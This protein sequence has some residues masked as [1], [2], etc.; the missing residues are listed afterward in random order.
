MRVLAFDQSYAR[1]GVGIAEDNKLLFCI[2]Y[3]LKYFKDKTQKRLFV[4]ALVKACIHR[5]RPDT[6]IVE[7]VRVFSQKFISKNTIGALATLIAAIID[8]SRMQV[9]SVETRAWKARVLGSAKATKDDAVKFVKRFGFEVDHD[10]AD[11]AGM[12][13]YPFCNKPLLKEEKA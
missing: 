4:R 12:A 11:A 1:I 2:S 8:A 7:R 9:Y 3:D 6:L 13:L 5:W 10:A